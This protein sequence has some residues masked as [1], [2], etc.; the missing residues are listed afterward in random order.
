[1]TEPRMEITAP[2]AL[3]TRPNGDLLFY[4]VIGDDWDE[5]DAASVIRTIDGLGAPENLTLRINSPGGYMSEGFAIFNYLQ[6]HP[7]NKTVMVDSLAASMASVIAMTGNRIIM[8]ENAMMMIHNPWGMAVGESDDMRKYADLLEVQRAQAIS[9]YVARTG[10]SEDEIAAM[11]DAETW[12]TAEEAVANGFADE[13][14]RSED[15][16]SEMKFDLSAFS[17]APERLHDRNGKSMKDP[18]EMSMQEAAALAAEQKGKEPDMLATDQ[19]PGSK[20]AQ[21][22]AP[23]NRQQQ[24]ATTTDNSSATAADAATPVMQSD[25]TTRIR[26]EATEAERVRASGIQAAVTAAR[27][28]VEFASEMI[29]EGITLDAARAKIIDRFAEQDATPE[30]QNHLRVTMVSDS[31]DRFREGAELAIMARAGMPGG[32]RNEFT[33]L[34]LRELARESLHVRNLTTRG[35]SAMQMV[36][37]AFVP[38]MIGAG[39]S[40]SDFA[41][42]L[43]NVA[44]KAMLMGWEESEETFEQWTRSGTLTDFKAT[45]RVGLNLFDNLAEVPEGAEYTYG[46]VSDRKET[47]QL[48]TYGRKFSITRQA[49]IND[50]LNAFTMVPMKMGRAS[51][52]TI[53][54]LVYAVLTGNPTMADGVALFHANHSNL[55]SSGGAAPSTSTLDAMR[56][57]MG[58]QKDPDSK[59]AGLNIR[60]AF[61][62]VPLALEGV[63]KTALESEYDTASGDKRLPNSVRN[64]AEVVSD[65]RLDAA[66]STSWYG[67]ASP[68]ANDTIEVAY[69]DGVSEPWMESKDGWDVDGVEFKARIDAAVKA[70]DHR[71][72]YKNV[73]S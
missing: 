38:R 52:R 42:V 22:A 56:V 20:P 35:M 45:S 68:T 63:S 1:M 71:G 11:M 6:S 40:T 55:K 18:A 57:A 32:E 26:R 12:M 28:P 30:P 72:L 15:Q 2:R 23:A 25:E 51:K 70:L 64:M 73:G 31:V 9:I 3:A 62:I 44:N 16:F 37:N 7:A 67:A 5:L 61:V 14:A 17:H 34:A 21:A 19:K 58:K 27:L 66:S 24:P 53:G 4:G 50:D 60:P 39:H 10:R 65:A 49:I 33:G 13:I 69:L 41:N 43:A 48:A 36:G 54:N 47:I 46:S 8:A 59:S 29:A